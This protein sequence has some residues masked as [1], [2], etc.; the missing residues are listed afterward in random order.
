MTLDIFFF[1]S[2][3][4]A[5]LWKLGGRLFPPRAMEDV[6]LRHRIRYDASINTNNRHSLHRHRTVELGSISVCRVG[7][8]GQ[9][10]RERG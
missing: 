10:E 7:D 9:A 8:P 2:A 5:I 1:S 4:L 6:G 3:V